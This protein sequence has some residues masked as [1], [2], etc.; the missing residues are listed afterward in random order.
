[1]KTVRQ[2]RNLILLKKERKKKKQNDLFSNQI[3]QNDS[4]LFINS[5]KI[6]CK[7]LSFLN[8]YDL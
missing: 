5:I 4:F 1:M 3:F 7:S 8:Y 6:K 2:M